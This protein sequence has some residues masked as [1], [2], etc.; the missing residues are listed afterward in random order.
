MIK[1]DDYLY[2]GAINNNALNDN[3]DYYRYD[4]DHFKTLV[5]KRQ[6]REA[7]NY[8]KNFHF[9][10]EYGSDKNSQLMRNIEE[11]EHEARK[12]EKYYSSASPEDYEAM[13]FYDNIYNDNGSEY[14]LGVEYSDENGKRHLG[15]KYSNNYGM[16]KK[17]LGSSE[18]EEATSIRVEFQPEQRSGWFGWDKLRRDGYNS[19]ESFIDNN[20][21]F[22]K[23]MLQDL[24]QIGKDGKAIITIN[25]GDKRFNRLMECIYNT[26]ENI[27]KDFSPNII[28]SFL[29]RPEISNK[30]DRNRK[31]TIQ[32]LNKEGNVIDGGNIW[33]FYGMHSVIDRAYNAQSETIKNLQSQK[34][35]YTTTVAGPIFDGLEELK[36]RYASGEI[37]LKTFNSMYNRYYGD[38]DRVINALGSAYT[39]MFSNYANENP[40]DELLLPMDNVN[41]GEIINLISG[42]SKTDLSYTTMLAD[43]QIGTLITIKAKEPTKQ[44]PQGRKRTQ[45]FIPGLFHEQN[46]EKI[47]KDTKILATQEVND[48]ITYGYNYD[49]ADGSVVTRDD[50]GDFYYNNILISKDDAIDLVN[51]SI[52]AKRGYQKLLDRHINNNG[53]IINEEGFENEAKALAISAANELKPTVYF[54][55]SDGLEINPNTMTLNDVDY[56]FSKKAIGAEP[57]EENA[58]NMSSSEYSKYKDVYS[59]F[60]YFMSS[61]YDY[62]LKYNN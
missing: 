48:M 10:G 44:N 26:T 62:K 1:Y 61:M 58:Y 53:E 41:R 37:D 25:K 9:V 23:E 32:G 11:L 47:N 59:I 28:N 55:N 52:I 30:S 43:G 46:Q 3:K 20:G 22:T 42:V 2:T 4:D 36:E 19:Y 18:N 16:Y 50:V 27:E 60:D 6:Y 21:Y 51:K 13:D 39:Q 31:I 45:V 17:S 15:N 29:N 56:I 35:D 57:T 38:V 54:K 34:K 14:L 24:V 40:T 5:A 12:T 49:L 33:G 8:L 7:A